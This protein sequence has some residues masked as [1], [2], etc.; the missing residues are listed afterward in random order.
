MNPRQPDGTRRGLG[1]IPDPFDP[2]DLIFEAQPQHFVGAIPSSVDLRNL[3]S[4][5]RDQGAQGSCTGFALAAGL[6]EFLEKKAGTPTPTVELSPAFVYYEERSR[7]GSI[8]NCDAGAM[9][10]DGLKVLAQT[11][12]SPEGDDPYS[13]QTCAAPSQK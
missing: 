4:P 6:R 2:R 9:I 5:V 3:C 10:R 12:V 1:L 8:Q 7:E 11:G 13:D